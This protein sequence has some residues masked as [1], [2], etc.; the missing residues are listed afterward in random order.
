MTKLLDILEE[1]LQWRR[2]VYRRIDGTTSLEDRESAIVDF[3]SHDSDCFIFLLSIRA[4]GRGLNLQSA[5]TVIIY[6]P[7]PN[8]KN[9]EQAVAR[10]HRIGQTRE[11]KVIYMEAV[12]DK[13]SSC[14][15]EDELRSGGTVDLEDD[16]VGK[17]RYM[18]S[19]ES[20]IRNNI[21]QYKIDMADEVINAGR[22]DQRT[23]HE[24]RRMTLETL[25]HDEERYQETMHDVPSLQEV[26]RM[27]A[28][29]KDEV[30]LFDQM[31]EE[32]DWTEEMTRYDQVPKWLRASSK[33]VDGTIAILSKK[34]S[35]AI[36]FADVMGMVSGEMETERKRVRPKGKKSPNYKEIDDENGDYSEASSDERNGYSAHEEEGEIQEI[37]DDE[38][39]DAVGAPPINKDQSEDDG[40]PCDGGYECHGALESTRNNDVLDEAGSSG[41][42]SDSQRVTRMISPVSPQKFGSLSALD[43]RPGSLPKKL[44]CSFYTYSCASLLTWVV[45]LSIYCSINIVQP[46]ELEEGEIAVSGDSHVD[47]QQSGSWMHD[48]DEGEDEQVLQPKIKRKRSIR[49]RPRHTVERPEEKSS[50]D[51][52]RGDSCLLPF[53]MDHKYQAQL[54]SD[55][56][57]KALVEPSGFKHD[58]I[59]SSTSRR[60]LPSRRIAKT[61]KLHASP[62]SGILHLQSAPAE[63]ATE[64]SRVSLDGK[65]PS[66]TGT[67]SLGTKMSD[68][69]Q[70]RV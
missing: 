29:S 4:A 16:L 51:V 46:D 33:E 39:S 59:D 47:R 60:N 11:V 2:L 68:V 25:L 18:G 38:S 62:K 61:P 45:L 55:T 14:Q 7:D 67:S 40:P 54:R 66:T 21:Q 58:Q 10:A 43:A 57:M 26:N 37:E 30:E 44:V 34:P 8:P 27:I 56:E 9:E 24:E 23:T 5:D 3:N 22:F 36:L 42:S 13:I 50:N 65:V 20:L 70:R 15:K 32:F 6:D 53:Q 35:K 63:D 64:H 1:Y 12:V 41:S 28:R 49:L 52:Q 69:I 31:D 17:D 19:I 48:R